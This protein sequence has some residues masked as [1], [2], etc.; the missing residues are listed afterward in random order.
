MCFQIWFP[1]QLQAIVLMRIG[2]LWPMYTTEF[3]QNGG[4]ELYAQCSSRVCNSSVMAAA[5]DG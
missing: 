4:K 2:A 1:N 5:H 3:A